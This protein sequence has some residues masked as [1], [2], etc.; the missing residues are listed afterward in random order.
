MSRYFCPSCECYFPLAGIPEDL[1]CPECGTVLE[2]DDEQP[3][4]D[5]CAEVM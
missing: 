5:E 4:D 1:C 3:Y 2:Y